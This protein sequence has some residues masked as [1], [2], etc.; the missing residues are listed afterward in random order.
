MSAEPSNLL[1]SKAE[2]AVKVCDFGFTILVRDRAKAQEM[3]GSPFYLAPEVLQG[4]GASPKSDVY[5]FGI[6]LHFLITGERVP[7]KGATEWAVEDVFRRVLEGG[8][9]ELPAKKMQ[10]PS[11]LRTLC[12]Q[13]WTPVRIL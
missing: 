2:N 8:R 4:S 5:A 1:Y 10:C 6:I 7:F 9:P 13:C 12:E 3:T 11:S